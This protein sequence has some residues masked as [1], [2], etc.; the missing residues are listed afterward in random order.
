MIGSN[1]NYALLTISE[2]SQLYA[3]QTENI[4]LMGAANPPLEFSTASKII[5]HQEQRGAFINKSIKVCQI[6][7][8]TKADTLK[9]FLAQMLHL[10]EINPELRIERNLNGQFLRLLEKDRLEA[11]WRFWKNEKLQKLFLS[12]KEQNKFV[13]NYEKGFIKN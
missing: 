1:D 6:T 11:E 3:L 2:F 4:F 8:E 5:L 7:G 13:E 10:A 9:P 12:E